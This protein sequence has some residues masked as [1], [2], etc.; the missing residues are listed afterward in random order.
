M[1][2]SEKARH[3]LYNRLTQV[4][5]EEPAETLMTAVPAYD[6]SE[7]LTRE[8]LQFHLA[9]ISAAIED[10]RRDMVRRF[11]QVD[12]R[13]EQVD[14]RFEQMDRRFEQMDQ[15]FEQMDRRLDQM[16]V[17][18]ELMERR[19]DSNDQRFLGIDQTLDSIG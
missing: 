4:L 16:D 7:I 10:L 18:L 2:I 3:D 12:R 5:G 17:R 9:P 11:E 15:R 19:I 8:N 6:P 13:F 14:Q 1:A